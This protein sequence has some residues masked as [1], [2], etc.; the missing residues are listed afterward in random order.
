MNP[1]ESARA[2]SA[3]RQGSLVA[4]PTETVYGLGAD[5]QNLEAVSRIFSVKGRPHD[6]PLIVHVSSEERI[7][8]WAQDIPSYALKLAQSFWPGPMTLILKRSG[9]ARDEITGGQDTVGL[10]VPNNETALAL[11]TEFE[12][13]GGKGVAA[14]SANRF[15][16]VSPTT[17]EAVRHELSDFLSDDDLILDGGS[18]QVGIESTIIDCTGDQPIILR[19]GAITPAMVEASTGLN[20]GEAHSRIRVSGSLESH[21]SPKAVVVLNSEPG[22]GD[23]LIAMNSIPTPQ[24]VVRLASPETTE[25]YAQVLY[26]AL[27]KAD[28][29]ELTKVIAITPEGDDI[30]VAITDRLKRASASS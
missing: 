1:E 17:A 5:A 26:A 3:L 4:F 23:G 11:L 6:H 22:E 7:G 10:R 12:R 27:R 21:Y 19:P 24:G 15:G 20:V 28:D 30:A 2:A 29:M 14:P 25:E 9:L 16:K 8:Q 13:L 18:C